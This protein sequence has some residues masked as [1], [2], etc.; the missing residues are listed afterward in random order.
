MTELSL[1]KKIHCVR[2]CYASENLVTTANAG[3]DFVVLR[4][5]VAG[6]VELGLRDAQSG[7]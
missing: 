1:K 6:S 5:G 7:S 2:L 3:A 4:F